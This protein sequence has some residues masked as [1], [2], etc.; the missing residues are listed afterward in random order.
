MS[1]SDKRLAARIIITR[2]RR[3]RLLSIVSQFRHSVETCGMYSRSFSNSYDVV[4][5]RERRWWL[6]QPLC[7]YQSNR[8]NIEILKS[9]CFAR[10]L[11]QEDVLVDVVG[12][13]IK[14]ELGRTVA[15]GSL[16]APLC[17]VHQLEEI[18]P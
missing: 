15:A 18:V 14:I 9:V 13:Q 5:S 2:D 16:V 6:R 12:V 4:G 1:A 17:Q 3:V 8:S 10:S 11:T 7:P